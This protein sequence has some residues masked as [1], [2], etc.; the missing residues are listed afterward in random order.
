L[1]VAEDRILVTEDKDF[2]DLVVRLGLPT[3]GIVLLR[4]DPADSNTKL[5][6]LRDV[7]HH[8]GARLPHSFVVVDE[9]KTRFRPLNAP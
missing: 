1:A 4:M 6:R 3:Y 2:G 7:I 9:F 5:A 8:D